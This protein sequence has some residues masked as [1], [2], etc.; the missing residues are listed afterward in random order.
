MFGVKYRYGLMI[1]LAGYSFLNILAVE[2]LVHYPIPT[3]QWAIMGLFLVVTILIWEGNR[4]ID[5][6]L[7]Q[8]RLTSF[9]RRVIYQF[10][11]SI[12]L[13]FIVA[14]STGLFTAYFTIA[15][16]WS[17]WVLPLK[18]FLMFCFRINLF[19]NTIHVIF[20]YSQKLENTQKEAENYKRISVQAQLQALQSQVN[21]HFLFNNLSVLSALIPTDT[22]ASVE[23]VKEFSKVYRY[24]LKSPEKELVT[25]AEELQFIQSYLYLLKTRFNGSL[26]IDIA[27]SPNL[28][29]SYVVPVALQMIIENAIKHNVASNNKPL[30]I[31]VSALGKEFLTIR[32]N[33]QPKVVNEETSTQL[34]L[35]NISQRYGFLAKKSIEVSKDATH[36][37]VKLPLLEVSTI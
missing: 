17:N 2:S 14:M 3:N 35:Q 25:L 7:S 37:S 26:N 4:L 28:H 27:V 29:Q 34:G 6:W 33:L 22:H 16:A 31:E 30:K 5:S 24:V 1:L 10:A 19:L 21:P 9:S 11:G 12:V 15:G 32:N 20:L 36:F 8:K 23:F 18:L 13:T